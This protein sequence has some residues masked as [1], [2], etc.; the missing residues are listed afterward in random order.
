M[1]NLCASALLAFL[2]GVVITCF[3]SHLPPRFLL[4]DAQPYGALYV[5]RVPFPN[6]GADPGADTAAEE[7]DE[8][9]DEEEEDE[10]GDSAVHPGQNQSSSSG[11]SSSRPTHR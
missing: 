10:E 1:E 4:Q 3:L 7:E 6:G 5:D 8:E 9:E 11:G 2:S